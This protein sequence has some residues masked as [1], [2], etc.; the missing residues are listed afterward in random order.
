MLLVYAIYEDTSLTKL[1][2]RVTLTGQ[3]AINMLETIKSVAGP[4]T[5][6]NRAKRYEKLGIIVERIEEPNFTIKA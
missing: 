2:K 1:R 6:D 3:D 5:H 4:M